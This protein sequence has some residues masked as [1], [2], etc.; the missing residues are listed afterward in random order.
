MSKEDRDTERYG[1]GYLHPDETV[2]GLQKWGFEYLDKS[3]PPAEVEEKREAFIQAHNEAVETYHDYMTRFMLC[4]TER[5]K[6][7]AVRADLRLEERLVT[8]ARRFMWITRGKT[9]F[10]NQIIRAESTAA[11]RNGEE[12]RAARAIALAEEKAREEAEMKADE[13]FG[14]F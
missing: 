6:I 5:A 13:R 11:D 9:D 8:H 7:S 12:L 14:M 4:G 10:A 2:E 3:T 1:K